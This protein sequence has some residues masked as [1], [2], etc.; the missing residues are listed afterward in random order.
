MKGSDWCICCTLWY[1]SGG[2][3]TRV[4]QKEVT[5]CS[6]IFLATTATPPLMSLLAWEKSMPYPPMSEKRGGAWH[7]TISVT[8][9]T[10]W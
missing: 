6:R 4:G 10:T 9:R 2:D 5:P 1:M 8:T 3:V 7:N